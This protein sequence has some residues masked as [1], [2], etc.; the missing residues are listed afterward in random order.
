MEE[1]IR[2]KVLSGEARLGGVG[3]VVGESGA[4]LYVGALLWY[5]L[6]RELEARASRVEFSPQEQAGLA[7]VRWLVETGRL[8]V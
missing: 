4:P 8:E 3:F 7:F 6:K 1:Q 2:A 5:E